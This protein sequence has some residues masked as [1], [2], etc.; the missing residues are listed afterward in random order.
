MKKVI[1]KHMMIEIMGD[2]TFMGKHVILVKDKV[3]TARTGTQASKIIN[4]L[5]KKY[6]NEILQI[7]YVPKADTLILSSASLEGKFS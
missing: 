1:K 2:P 6:P 7:T 4:K 3:F 5:E